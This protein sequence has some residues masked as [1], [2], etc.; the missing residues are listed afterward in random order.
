M[1]ADGVLVPSK[2]PASPGEFVNRDHR[3]IITPDG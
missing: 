3:G 2:M 1:G